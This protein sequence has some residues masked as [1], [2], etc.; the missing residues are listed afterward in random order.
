M[1]HCRQFLF[2]EKCGQ[3]FQIGKIAPQGVRRNVPLISEVGEEVKN[4]LLHE[5][6]LA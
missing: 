2:T 5:D 3:L 1:I 4:V 6:T